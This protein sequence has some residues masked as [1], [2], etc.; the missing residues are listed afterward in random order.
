MCLESKFDKV[1]AFL[2][3]CWNCRGYEQLSCSIVT[4]IFPQGYST[5]RKVI[6]EELPALPELLL[7]M[8]VL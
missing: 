3:Q 1:K 5:T 6:S 4:F 8:A 7:S 2:Y